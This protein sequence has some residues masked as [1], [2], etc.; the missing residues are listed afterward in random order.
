[1]HLIY[2]EDVEQKKCNRTLD[3]PDNRSHGLRT[4]SKDQA[5]PQSNWS[6]G[7]VAEQPRERGD[8]RM[9]MLVALDS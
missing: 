1:M 2:E 5:L 9:M 3:S 8:S 4:K 6:V 7:R